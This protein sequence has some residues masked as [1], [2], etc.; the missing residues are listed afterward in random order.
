[1]SQPDTNG[2]D[3]R[4]DQSLGE[5]LRAGVAIAAIVVLFGGVAY[6]VAAWNAPADHHTFQ[7]DELRTPTGIIRAAWERDVRGIIQL[8]LLLL[9]A[10]PIARVVFTVFAFA[11]QRDWAYVVITLIV[12]GLLLFCLF[13]GT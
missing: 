11:R 3:R 7:P 6:V 5:L 10:T 1:M 4:L 12:L 9:L 8:G 2:T 13:H